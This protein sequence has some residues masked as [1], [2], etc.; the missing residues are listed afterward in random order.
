MPPGPQDVIYN[1]VITLYFKARTPGNLSLDIVNTTPLAAGPETYHYSTENLPANATLQQIV[2]AGEDIY[3]TQYSNSARATSG[4]YSDTASFPLMPWASTTLKVYSYLPTIDDVSGVNRLG[5]WERMPGPA[6]VING[7]SVLTWIPAVVTCAPVGYGTLPVTY[8]KTD[9]AIDQYGVCNPNAPSTSPI[10]SHRYP[11]LN[12]LSAGSTLEQVVNSGV[13]IYNPSNQNAISIGSAS[14]YCEN[15][16]PSN[17]QDSTIY[18]LLS[19][20]SVNGTCTWSDEIYE[21]DRIVAPAGTV[22]TL[23]FAGTYYSASLNAC[24]TENTRYVYYVSDTIYSSVEE[25]AVNEVPIFKTSDQ[26]PDEVLPEYWQ[27]ENASFGFY[28]TNNSQFYIWDPLHVIFPGYT[29][30]SW[31]TL[32]NGVNEEPQQLED[33]WGFDTYNTINCDLEEGVTVKAILAWKGVPW[34]LPTPVGYPGIR[35]CKSALTSENKT[36]IFYRSDIDLS[37]LEI[38]E[39]QLTAY[40]TYEG[41]AYDLQDKIHSQSYFCEIPG[42]IYFFR[43]YDLDAGAAWRGKH[44]IICSPEWNYPYEC[45]TAARLTWPDG[46]LTNTY[47]YKINTSYDVANV[48]DIENE[49]CIRFKTIT[50]LNYFKH[51]GASLFPLNELAKY[52]IQLWQQSEGGDL[53]GLSENTAIGSNLTSHY[54]YDI[55]GDHEVYRGVNSDGDVSSFGIQGPIPC[56]EFESP[57][58]GVQVISDGSGIG[59]FYAFKTCA[60]ISGQQRIYLVYGNHTSETPESERGEIYEFTNQIGF[61]ATF[62]TYDWLDEENDFLLE[63]LE[64]NSAKT[65]IHTVV[66][67]SPASAR[68]ILS[69][70]GYDYDS[71]IFVEPQVIGLVGISVVRY[72]ENENCFDCINTTPT[73]LSQFSFKEPIVIEDEVFDV[74]KDIEK[75]YKL[76]NLSRPLFRTNPKITSNIKVII[77]SSN[78]LYLES[79]NATK[80]LADSKYKAYS[81]SPSGS[82]S[83]DVA[84]FYNDNRTPYEMAYS[85]KRDSSDYSVLDDYSKQFEDEYQYG[86]RFNTSKMYNES[87]RMFAPIWLDLNVPKHFL[88]YRVN[89]PSPALDLSDSGE[90]KSTRVDYM[91][92]NATLVKSFDLS[93]NS[94]A[95][96]YI[97]NHINDTDFPKN[98]V[99]VSFE[100]NEQTYFN[101]IDIQHGGFTRKGE[102]IHR[103]FIAT[104]KTLIE[105]N[106]FIT[107]G[108]RRNRLVSANIM[109]LEF[110]FDDTSADEF[111]VNRY[112]GVYADEVPSGRGEISNINK[113]L[114]KFSK[115]ESYMDSDDVTY[116][117]PDYKMLKQAPIMGYITSKNGFINILNGSYY[118]ADSYNVKIA[119]TN[120]NVDDYRGVVSTGR[121]VAIKKNPDA[122]YDFVKLTV[123]DN[124]LDLDQI[125]VVD[126]KRESYRLSFVNHIPNNPSD[127]IKTSYPVV[128]E[129]QFNSGNSIDEGLQNIVDAIEANIILSASFSAEVETIKDVNGELINTV[130]IS[131]KRIGLTDISLTVNRGNPSSVIRVEKLS[132]GVNILDNTFIATSSLDAGRTD[133][134]Y[135]SSNGTTGQVAIALTSCINSKG[136]FNAVN[137]GS[138]IYIISKA[139]GYKLMRSAVMISNNNVANFV[140]IDNEDVTNDLDLSSDALSKYTTYGLKGG[141][142]AGRSAFIHKD[143][144]GAIEIG[145]LLPNTISGVYSEVIDIVENIDDISGDYY[146]IVFKT[147]NDLKDGEY[148]V[149][150]EFKSEIG[151]FSCYDFYDMDFDFYD[152][153]NSKLKELELETVEN[154][155]YTPSSDESLI[156]GELINGDYFKPSSELFS[157]ILPLLNQESPEDLQSISIDSEYDR[158]NENYIKELSTVSRVVPTINKFVL[159]GCK[160]VRNNPYYLNTNEA[161]GRT[162]FSPDINVLDR[163]AA[164]FTHEWFYI[165]DLPDYF[166]YDTTN[167]AFSYVN[168]IKGINVSKEL[169]MSSEFDYFDRYMVSEGFTVEVEDDP[170]NEYDNF[171]IFTK[172]S[173]DRKYSLLNGGTDRA[174]SSTFFNGIKVLAKKRKEISNEIASEFIKDSSM[175]GYRFSTLVK[176]NTG[177]TVIS[178]DVSYDVIKN[179]AFKF[180]ILFIEVDLNEKY[181]TGKINRRTLYTLDN[182]LTSFENTYAYD[183]IDISGALIFSGINFNAGG[184]Y[185]VN[186]VTHNNGGEPNL[187]IQISVLD[188]DVY[189][190]IE[191]DYGTTDEDGLPILYTVKIKSV[192]GYKRLVID[193]PPVDG[194]GNVLDTTYIPYSLQLSAKYT[195]KGG[196]KNAHAE[197]L[198]RLSAANVSNL[199][200]ANDQS[201]KY[202]TIKTDGTVVYNDFVLNFEDGNEIIKK[203]TLASTE[204]T[205]KPSTYSLFNGTIG[206]NLSERSPYYPFLIRHAGNYTVSLKPVLTFTDVYTHHKIETNYY[207]PLS[208][209]LESELTN[210]M[211]KHSISSEDEIDRAIAYYKKFNRLG[212]AFNIGFIQGNHDESWAMIKNHFYHKVNEDNP[213]GVTKLSESSE[214]LPLYPLIGEIAI[215]KTDINVL[216]SSWEN[217]YYTKSISGGSGS[218]VPGTV[219]SKENRSYMSSTLMKLMDSYSISAFTTQ[220]VS[221]KSQLEQILRNGNNDGSAVLFENDNQVIIDFYLANSIV[222][223]FVELGVLNEIT[224]YVDPQF[225]ELDKT[226]ITD[227]AQLYVVNNLIS[228][229]SVDAIELYVSRLKDASSSIE[230]VYSLDLIDNGGF[231]RDDNFSITKH[232][233]SSVN[234]RLIYNKSLGYSY[235]MRPLIK[236]KK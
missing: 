230:S 126:I 100:K 26:F 204:D 179:E 199:L 217:D 52:N 152:N 110:M 226:S 3:F 37:L 196:G 197:F 114:V 128:S 160:T 77:D 214:Y 39:K 206:Y 231:V 59:I 221:D 180:I 201:V 154:T 86:A 176:F 107:D 134:N 198:K 87:F 224:K 218:K 9:A 45:P 2:E 85:V 169:F 184:P 216:R 31:L 211:Y 146:K 68:N 30:T 220:T 65:Y 219:S 15:P 103:D 48:Y 64:V 71:I 36:Y 99:S 104:D 233:N 73:S 27:L 40:S 121:S 145:E 83:Y 158:L 60:K 97:R 93:E 123:N 18:R 234:F 49:Y 25:L 13:V 14:Y 205:E 200:N 108:F 22:R 170:T 150:Y 109:N 171:D 166:E 21:C 185:E 20:S 125:T 120:A 88:I 33:S 164:S 54:I 23:S 56:Y 177:D 19:A 47:V 232:P 191:I 122:G 79:I 5:T 144:L 162:N 132:T 61:G 222:D 202:S 148:G 207:N 102:F 159:E 130:V 182:K 167:E 115:L 172:T 178:N 225:S 208:F 227:D 35:L 195:Y 32:I 112:I 70:I 139:T 29:S 215:D 17:A 117:I 80:D 138:D 189:G 193:G 187:D 1:G 50:A 163:D 131:E 173:L 213:T 175:N 8:R 228:V 84:R 28:G 11:L 147:K 155:N 124:P 105:S 7:V 116:A 78:G 94:K 43:K 62:F 53:T 149:L 235:T 90:D 190:D 194:L 151:L 192:D 174:F 74:R 51:P 203:S 12:G 140:A 161:F 95:G 16:F 111:T 92:R 113:G 223:K 153:S 82:Y 24:G 10:T 181:I 186:A 209:L 129:I 66:A 118:N 58:S 96:Q 72:F 141:N 91:L 89:G 137:N 98:M 135:Y 42:L 188:G 183:D 236:I 142:S 75:N 106:D 57:I 4:W 6:E 168:F 81:V 136:N 143:S 44:G 212:V 119:D 210:K 69:S 101:G 38:A 157:N 55:D 46:G 133:G 67:D 63:D 76:D 229:F 127:T 156:G 41:A 165:A 34:F